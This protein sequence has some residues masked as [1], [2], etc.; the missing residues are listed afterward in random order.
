MINVS[1]F[2]RELVTVLPGT[3]H[4]HASVLLP[5]LS[6]RPYQIRHAVVASLAE[7]VAAGHED[8]MAAAAAAAGGGEGGGGSAG[9]DGVSAAAG[10]KDGGEDESQVWLNDT[11]AFA[12]VCI[13]IATRYVL[14]VLSIG[15]NRTT[16]CAKSSPCWVSFVSERGGESLAPTL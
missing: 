11:L 16:A 6:S 14:I 8:K 15:A 12:R 2:L 5:H 3:V 4:A 9:A 13:E 10:S 7:V 1:E